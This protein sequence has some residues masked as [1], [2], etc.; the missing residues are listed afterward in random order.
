MKHIH[1]FTRLPVASLALLLLVICSD[2][3]ALPPNAATSKPASLAKPVKTTINIEKIS[4]SDFLSRIE[5]AENQIITL[6][7]SQY[8]QYGEPNFQKTVYDRLVK[9]YIETG[10]LPRIQPEIQKIAKSW[11]QLDTD[12]FQQALQ[13]LQQSRAYAQQHGSVSPE[14]ATYLENGMLL[15]GLKAVSQREMFD[16]QI[17]ILMDMAVWERDNQLREETLNNRNLPLDT[18]FRRDYE[19]EIAANKAKLD[20][21]RHALKILIEVGGKNFE[22]PVFSATGT[23]A[24]ER[25]PLPVAE[26][27][28][29]RLRQRQVKAQALRKDYQQERDQLA[30]QLQGKQA[31]Y[32][33]LKKQMVAL[34]QQLLQKFQPPVEIAGKVPKA[35]T[36]SAVVTVLKAKIRAVE[37]AIL[38][39]Q[40]NGAGAENLSRFRELDALNL[41]LEKATAKRGL[42][43]VNG[44]AAPSMQVLESEMASLT[45][46]KNVLQRELER[47]QQRIQDLDIKLQ[48]L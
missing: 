13:T 27:N 4:L 26:L 16:S 45:E 43:V 12:F 28:Q 6:R 24:A 44:T 42:P 1:S 15:W 10:V 32:D 20:V 35:E 7:D 18:Y 11:K 34:E 31:E 30:P 46:K 5:A 41:Q 38:A 19:F 3:Y 8:S 2:V 33:A 37:E 9:F 21:S 25:I 29:A 39:G 40:K 48:K 23:P 22:K 47:L 14:D 36:D 17:K